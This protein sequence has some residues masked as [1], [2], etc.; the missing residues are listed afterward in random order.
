VI[1]AHREIVAERVGVS[2]ALDLAD[3]TPEDVGRVAVLLVAGDDTTLA[4]NAFGHVEVEAVLFAGAGRR[5]EREI[6]RNAAVRAQF[7]GKSVCG[8]EDEGF[9]AGLYAL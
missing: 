9:V 4:A 1:A 6:E 7:R 3:A 5:R 8:G 2:A